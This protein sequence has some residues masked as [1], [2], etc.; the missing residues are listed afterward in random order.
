MWGRVWQEGV[1]TPGLQVYE[2]PQRRA[3]RQQAL[4]G[5]QS[6]AQ[7]AMGTMGGKDGLVKVPDQ[8]P[9]TWE[10]GDHSWA[11]DRDYGVGQRPTTGIW[12]DKGVL[13]GGGA[14]AEEEEEEEEKE[15]ADEEEAGVEPAPAPAAAPAQEEPAAEKEEPAA[16]EAPAP[17]EAPPAAAPAAEPAAAPEPA[18]AEPSGDGGG[19]GGG[20]GGG[21]TENHYYVNVPPPVQ[22]VLPDRQSGPAARLSSS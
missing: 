8:P 4:A 2:V 13:P 6:K 1:F 20:G 22:Q 3:A 5:Y 11:Y 7:I 17:A 19:D 16:E 12:A 15:K 21:G 10:R 14:P 18:A 9:P